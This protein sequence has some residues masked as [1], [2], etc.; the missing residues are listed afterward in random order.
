MA[1]ISRKHNN[2]TCIFSIVSK[3]W[4]RVGNFLNARCSKDVGNKWMFFSGRGA[5]LNDALASPPVNPAGSIY[6]YHN[7]VHYE[8][9]L[10][11]EKNL[12]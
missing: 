4:G 2:Y 6:L 8:P 7:G 9:I 12:S 3:I 10:G 1:S 5:N 11:V